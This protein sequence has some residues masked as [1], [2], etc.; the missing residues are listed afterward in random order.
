MSLSGK[1][2]DHDLVLRDSDEN[3]RTPFQQRDMLS[4]F[5]SLNLKKHPNDTKRQWDTWWDM[6]DF[7]RV[8]VSH[9]TLDV[10]IN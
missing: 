3:I 4:S 9:W 5:Q 2:G 7:N 1:N 6:T 8:F 10:L